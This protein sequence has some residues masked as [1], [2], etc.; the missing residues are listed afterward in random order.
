VCVCVFV[1]DCVYC[2]YLPNPRVFCCSLSQVAGAK[3]SS[4]DLDRARENAET[5]LPEA[6]ILHEIIWPGAEVDEKASKPGLSSVA[7]KLPLTQDEA[8]FKETTVT[9]SVMIC[10]IAAAVKRPKRTNKHKEPVLDFFR[11]LMSVS[12]ALAGRLTFPHLR[13]GD[14][15]QVDLVMQP[16]GLIDAS[17]FWTTQFF[18]RAISKCWRKALSNPTKT[19]IKT[20]RPV[21]GQV[22]LHELL[23]FLLDF[24]ILLEVCLPRTLHLMG[25]F[26]ALL[27]DMTPNFTSD[28]VSKVYTTRKRSAFEVNAAQ[29]KVATAI[30]DG[31][32]PRVT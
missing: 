21:S 2:V 4:S 23:G 18:D 30:W 26:A 17:L 14:N 15:V 27:E 25:V 10:M 12:C 19:W 22:P 24:A 31:S 32:E 5:A 8:R 9:T 16:D 1:C 29:L 7:A 13:F 3:A 28:V 20:V 11:H 6:K